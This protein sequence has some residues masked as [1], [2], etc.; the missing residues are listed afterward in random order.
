MIEKNNYI[1]DLDNEEIEEIKYYKSLFK[2]LSNELESI[3]LLFY[4]I[5]NYKL[6]IF[7]IFMRY[8]NKN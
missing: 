2:K 7:Y 5:Y 8:I 1:R 6:K 4:E 3:D